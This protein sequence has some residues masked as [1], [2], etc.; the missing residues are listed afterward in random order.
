M[1]A[2]TPPES[3]ETTE[4]TS[5]PSVPEYDQSSDKGIFPNPNYSPHPDLFTC[6]G[7]PDGTHRDHMCCLNVCLYKLEQLDSY[8]HLYP[9]AQSRW[10]KCR[11][12]A[13]KHMET[14]YFK[15]SDSRI[16]VQSLL[17]SGWPDRPI[18]EEEKADDVEP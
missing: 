17:N 15:D 11:T 7:Y 10:E 8:R 14:A 9:D 2:E 5:I 18:K 6:D 12:E 3:E 16:R 13:L 4:E 1:T